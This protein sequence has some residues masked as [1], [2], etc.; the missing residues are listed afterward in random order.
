MRLFFLLKLFLVVYTILFSIRAQA[1]ESCAVFK[2]S[3]YEGKFCNSGT[4]RAIFDVEIRSRNGSQLD[5]FL[6]YSGHPIRIVRRKKTLHF[7][8]GK[9]L[10]GSFT[11]ISDF[12]EIKFE[13]IVSHSEIST[14]LF[15]YEV[16]GKTT[17]LC[18]RRELLKAYKSF[19]NRKVKESSYSNLVDLLYQR[20]QLSKSLNVDVPKIVFPD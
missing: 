19:S 12:N 10:M 7:Y 13:N 9:R 16:L 18:N 15:D 20:C 4:G 14:L 17:T 8:D 3:R 11:P 5:F 2:F 6:H 1:F